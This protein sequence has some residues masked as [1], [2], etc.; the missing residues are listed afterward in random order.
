MTF[1]STRRDFLRLSLLAAFDAAPVRALVTEKTARTQARLEELAPETIVP[2]GWLKTYLERQASALCYAL[3]DISWPFSANYWDGEEKAESW[4]PWE[5]T[6]YWVDGAVRCALVTGDE[7]LLKRVMERVRYTL[8]HP[9]G[10]F[11]GPDAIKDPTQSFHRWPHAIFFRALMALSDAGVVQNIPATL[12]QFYLSDKADYSLLARNVVNVETMLWCYSRT[13]DRRMLSLAESAWNGYVN[14]NPQDPAS[15]SE[16]AVESGGPI[17]AHGVTYAEI[18]KLPAILYIYTGKYEYRNYAEKAQQRI[19]DHHMLLDGIPSTTEYFRGTTSLDS[20]E[21][22]DITDHTWSWSYMLAATGNGIWADRIER[23]C[24]NAGFG[25]IRKDWKGLQYFSSLNQVVAN[26][27][28]NHNTLKR[29]NYWMA[30][31]ESRLLRHEA[32]LTDKSAASARDSALL[33]YC[34]KHAATFFLQIPSIILQH[35]RELIAHHHFQAQ[36]G[37]RSLGLATLSRG[38]PRY[39]VFCHV[40]PYTRFKAKVGE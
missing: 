2:E 26:L 14:G 38:K 9:K 4:W 17:K 18:S 40:L 3:P 35:H 20:H 29:G 22:C 31:Q 36:G 34:L 12:Q 7:K 6:A 15:L 28:S 11:L 8:D 30:Y 1:T 21:T 16:S 33:E 10:D 27:T 19:F 25:A 37:F 5:Q 39:Q 32:S 13:K 24:F 23:A